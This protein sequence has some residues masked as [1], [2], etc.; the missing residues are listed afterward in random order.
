MR[1]A[2]SSASASPGSCE[3]SSAVSRL[4]SSFWSSRWSGMSRSDSGTPPSGSS[5]ARS[6]LARSISS[7]WRLVAFID[8]PSM[9][10]SLRFRRKPPPPAARTASRVAS[11]S[12]SAASSGF[13]GSSV[14]RSAAMLVPRSAASAASGGGAGRPNPP[15]ASAY[16]TFAAAAARRAAELGGG[17]GASAARPLRASTSA[18]TCSPRP[19]PR[20]SAG[21]HAHCAKS[22]PPAKSRA[23]PVAMVAR[24]EAAGSPPTRT[25]AMRCMPSRSQSGVNGSSA[26]NWYCLGAASARGSPA[27]APGTATGTA[28]TNV[29]S[30]TPFSN[31]SSRADRGHFVTDNTNAC[32]TS[33]A[34]DPFALRLRGCEVPGTTRPFTSSATQK[35]AAR[36]FCLRSRSHL[37]VVA[38]SSSPPPRVPRGSLAAS[39]GSTAPVL[40]SWNTVSRT[41]V[42]LAPT[43]ARTRSIAVCRSIMCRTDCAPRSVSS[44]AS[45]VASSASSRN[46]ARRSAGAAPPSQSAVPAAI[47]SCSAFAR[48]IAA[49]LLVSYRRTSWAASRRLYERNA[50]SRRAAR[51]SSRPIS[52]CAVNSRR[53]T[54]TSSRCTRW[55]SPAPSASAASASASASYSLPGLSCR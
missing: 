51:W 54:R 15:G 45:R 26:L 52:G 2:R 50:S 37:G 42:A 24:S 10:S 14:A 40:S 44:A 34:N 39:T 12:S 7:C 6:P 18:R 41:A 1:L 27:A 3:D 35:R 29:S 55:C 20:S 38:A 23:A 8:A 47:S 53:P 17:G 13:R 11:V 31:T 4:S 48:A 16:P 46:A 32:A 30:T 43:I 9:V 22:D 25:C 36:A 5:T 19:N 28:A 49:A 21:T 33:S